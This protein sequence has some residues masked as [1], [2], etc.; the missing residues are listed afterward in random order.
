M[1]VSRL[2]ATAGRDS[3][4]LAGVSER[5]AFLSG[6]RGA[7]ILVAALTVAAFLL[8]LPHIDESLIL[9]EH[10]AY[11]ETHVPGF[12]D[13]I[14]HVRDGGE[15]S[16]P[17]YFVLAWAAMK[18]GDPTVLIRLPS[19]LLSTATVPVVY[20]LG[21]RTVGR[22]AGVIAAALLALSPFAIYYASEARP[23]ATMMFFVACSTLVLLVALERGG[24]RWWALYALI[25]CAIIYAHYFGAFALVAQGAWALWAHRDRLR[26]LVLVH[27]AIA[28][29]FVP[30]LLIWVDQKGNSISQLSSYWPLGAKE[31]G[32]ELVRMFPG[33]PLFFPSDLPGRAAIVLIGV[34]LAVALAAR[35]AKGIPKP[36][37]M[38]VLLLMLA[39]VPPIGFVAYSELGPNIVIARYMSAAL[40]AV[41]LLLGTALAS[42]PKLVSLAASAAVIGCLAVGTFEGQQPDRQRPAWREAAHFIDRNARPGDVVVEADCG[43][44]VT[45]DC[46]RW[47]QNPS[48][49]VSF[50]KQH[51]TTYAARRFFTDPP[52]RSRLFV[53]GIA[54]G[55]LQAPRPTEK[56]A[57]CL[58]HHREFE[59]QTPV[60][61][62]VYAHAAPAGTLAR[63]GGQ[64]VIALPSGAIPVAPG[65]ADGGL[66][67]VATG[68]SAV[69]LD[70]WALGP[71]R[72]PAGCLLVFA[73]GR[74]VGSA[75]ATVARADIGKL[76]GAS[77][78]MS[79][80]QLTIPGTGVEAADLR[81]FA[82]ADGEAAELK[83]A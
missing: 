6:A 43:F 9:D 25:A 83:P 42:P 1:A 54:T 13:V 19:L 39:V 53:T 22:R 64:E 52:P 18:L 62:N 23:Y 44:K 38:L 5:L 70:A 74:L 33:H 69:S 4:R 82:V 45:K 71:S 7:W 58:I 28:V 76:Y 63:R 10:Y 73:N 27:V 37:P 20:L 48:L 46:I 11:A 55:L 26:E 81:V 3:G 49:N 61:V 67:R 56:D 80:F 60:V 36:S 12:W 57:M 16:P 59:G 68:S 77:S 17:L 40:P 78:V 51:R 35:V 29:G 65:A 75:P 32:R 79:G 14:E 21:V 30:W 31:V 2:K 66:D 8:R 34:A 72:Q 24:R 50:E 47:S 15:N 41:T